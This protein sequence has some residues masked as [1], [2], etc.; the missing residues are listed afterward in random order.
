MAEN[1]LHRKKERKYILTTRTLCGQIFIY[2]KCFVV[3]GVS[4]VSL[5]IWRKSWANF[6]CYYSEFVTEWVIN[7]LSIPR[8][9][10]LKHPQSGISLD[11]NAIK[12]S[13][14]IWWT[15]PSIYEMMYRPIIIQLDYWTYIPQINTPLIQLLLGFF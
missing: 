5:V 6:N 3:K 2:K 14:L 1:V 12:I 4:N 11:F 10:S 8:I 9:I 13:G 15:F 7:S